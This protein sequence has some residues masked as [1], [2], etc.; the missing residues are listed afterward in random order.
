MKTFAIVLFALVLFLSCSN[1]GIEPEVIRVNADSMSTQGFQ[2]QRVDTIELETT[3]SNLIGGIQKLEFYKD[4]I[5]ILDVWY[6]KAL[7]V[8]D[9][10][11]RFISK[12]IVGHGPGEVVNPFAFSVDKV[13]DRILLWDQ[14]LSSM[15]EYDLDLNF[16]SVKEHRI[17]VRDFAQLGLDTF[18]IVSYK[19]MPDNGK[20]LST[21]A[22]FSNGFTNEIGRYLPIGSDRETLFMSNPISVSNRVL[23][24]TPLDYS[25]YTYNNEIQP[26][27]TCDFGSHQFTEAEL[28]LP[29]ENVMELGLKD[30]VL[31]ISDLI[32]SE[33]FIGFQYGLNRKARCCLYDKTS[34]KTFHINSFFDDGTLP[35]ISVLGLIDPK[36]DLLVGEITDSNYKSERINLNPSLLVFQA[37]GE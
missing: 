8:F 34:K 25:I 29:F 7:F 20:V 28:K 27:Y 17:F 10:D 37:I 33:H 12:T 5:Y 4:R 3:A 30:K 6:S 16:K 2:I 13:N 36:N 18:L 23:F 24:T 32:E 1:T 35:E 15:F 26:I 9:R 11:G 31:S 22:L 21:Y 19:P 14:A